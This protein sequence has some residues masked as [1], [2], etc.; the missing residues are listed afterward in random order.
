MILATIGVSV[1]VEEDSL[2]QLVDSEVEAGVRHRGD[3]LIYSLLVL[4]IELVKV[5]LELDVAV[6]AFASLDTELEM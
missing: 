1:I 3:D 6:L 4:V 5:E 2:A